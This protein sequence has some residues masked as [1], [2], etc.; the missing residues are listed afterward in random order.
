ML[1]PSALF[2]EVLRKWSTYFSRRSHAVKLAVRDASLILPNN[3]ETESLIRSMGGAPEKML[4]LTQSFL[5]VE[6][7]SDLSSRSKITPLECGELRIVAGGILEGRKGVAIVLKAL[8]ILS[9]QK[10]PFRFH[11]LGKGPE[12]AYLKELSERLGISDRVKFF[13]F[14]KG[15]E[16]MAQLKAAHIY[17]LPSVRE[18]FGLT[19]MEAMAAGCVPI[20]ADCGGPAMMSRSSG[21]EPIAVSSFM[22]MANEIADRAKILWDK[23]DY[24]REAS[25]RSCES[26]IHGYSTEHYIRIIKECYSL[27]SKKDAR[28]V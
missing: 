28:T 3:P 6:R 22:I 21:L 20:V 9:P 24:W 13:D 27:V 4:R 19:Q 26:I 11:F 16:F 2:F 1:S 23:P 10:I 8:S 14:L 18:G 15:E 17:M 7:L 5:S 25:L 12:G